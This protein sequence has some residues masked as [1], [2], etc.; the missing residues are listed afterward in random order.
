VSASMLG[1]VALWLVYLSIGLVA[2]FAL[3]RL[4]LDHLSRLVVVGIALWAIV[5]LVDEWRRA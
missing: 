1:L 4:G 3:L 5:S 2:H